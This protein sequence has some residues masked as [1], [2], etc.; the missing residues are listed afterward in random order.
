MRPRVNH[1][2][3]R[4]APPFPPTSQTNEAYWPIIATKDQIPH[5]LRDND[6]IVRGHPMPTYSYR[7]SFRLWRCLHMETM[8]IWS[9]IVGSTASVA[10]R[11][12]LYAY[13]RQGPAT[14]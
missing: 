11:F 6:F 1:P 5:W 13:S 14:L 3:L 2:P 10:T 12:A 7:R 9:H 4:Q 8:N